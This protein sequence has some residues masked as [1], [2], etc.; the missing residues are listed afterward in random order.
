MSKSKGI[1][2]SQSSNQA[3]MMFFGLCVYACTHTHRHAHTH[4]YLY[5][6]AHVCGFSSVTFLLFL[7]I[8]S[9]TEPG[10]HKFGSTACLYLTSP[11]VLGF[12]WGSKQGL[13][14]MQQALYQP[15]CLLIPSVFSLPLYLRWSHYVDLAD[16]ELTEINLS[17]P[18]EYWD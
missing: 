15:S 1:V 10:A 11:E 4:A 14:H 12:L 5:V 3:S 16:L 6:G 9:L 2:R 18:P 7:R 17:L 8:G 13:T